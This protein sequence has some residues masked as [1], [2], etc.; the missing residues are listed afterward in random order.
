[1]FLLPLSSTHSRLTL[2]CYCSS[3]SGSLTPFA[4]HLLSHSLHFPAASFPCLTRSGQPRRVCLL[5][6]CHPPSSLLHVAV[7]FAFSVPLVADSRREL[8]LIVPL[9]ADSCGELD[10]GDV[11][12]RLSTVLLSSM[13]LADDDSTTGCAFSIACTYY[14]TVG[15]M[16]ILLPLLLIPLVCSFS[17]Y[18][19]HSG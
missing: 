8:S 6:L 13:L 11:A 1:M 3:D 16:F 18:Q 10:F 5:R 14:K 7:N 12:L 19:A 4:I 2:K 17:R 15:T 9:A